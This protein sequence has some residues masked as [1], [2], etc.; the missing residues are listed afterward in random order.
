[1]Q[2]RVTAMAAA[3]FACLALLGCAQ[4]E[5]RITPEPI[6]VTKEATAAVVAAPVSGDIGAAPGDLPL[7][8]GATVE[9]VESRG[10]AYTLSMIT[11]DPYDDVFAGV[12]VGFE[13]AGWQVAVED[14]AA[15]DSSA[16]GT[17]TVSSQT[18]DGL[19]AVEQLENGSTSIEYILTSK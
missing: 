3:L 8:P 7:W 18:A 10:G 19:V 14:S 1:M 11:G 15:S 9:Y 17:I 2:V 12:G 6:V 16:S 5:S 13:R 4:I